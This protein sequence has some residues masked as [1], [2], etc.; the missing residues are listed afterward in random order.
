MSIS[1]D[2]ALYLRDH[3]R[4]F[5]GL[6]VGDRGVLFTLAFRVGSN[7]TT[8]IS[9]RV[10]SQELCIHET[11][12][13][14]HLSNL[15]K[16][17]LIEIKNGS[18][19]KRK[20]EYKIAEIL[21]NYHQASRICEKNYQAKSLG[22]FKSIER[23]HS[24]FLESTERNRS[25]I[26]CTNTSEDIDS[27]KEIHQEKTPKVTY[28]NKVTLRDKVKEE[29][30]RKKSSL[31]VLPSFLSETLWKEFLEHRKSIK[32]PMSEIAQKKAFKVLEKL[33]EEGQD[34]EQVVNNSII[35]GWK[36]LFPI[37]EKAYGNANSN[38][39]SG[40]GGKE[41]FDVMRYL[42]NERD[43][44]RNSNAAKINVSQ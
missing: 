24:V 32:S 38:E 13:R 2:I 42:I 18:K 1:L 15:E 35:N 31:L 21:T 8:W 19:D 3:G 16:F 23:N 39:K 41:E 5:K 12:L 7:S 30:A 17:G 36:G 27:T 25:I 22:N 11:N 26:S 4:R 9:Q 33:K 28:I 37:K 14:K 6:S 40:N 20:R 10:L 43:R 34:V 44:I 29:H